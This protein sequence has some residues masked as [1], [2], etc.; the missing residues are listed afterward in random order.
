[1]LVWV[2]VLLFGFLSVIYVFYVC[3]SN[4]NKLMLY[5]SL[6]SSNSVP[7]NSGFTSKSQ[8]LLT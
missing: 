3:I 7:V 6:C 4:K 2:E 8:S 1:M 5:L